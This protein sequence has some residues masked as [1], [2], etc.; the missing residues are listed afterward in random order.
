MVF[1]CRFEIMALRHYDVLY[2]YVVYKY[3]SVGDTISL[4]GWTLDGTENIL[5]MILFAR[6]YDR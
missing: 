1:N 2:V 4:H 5:L 6:I 3:M